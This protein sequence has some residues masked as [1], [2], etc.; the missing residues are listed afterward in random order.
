MQNSNTILLTLAI[1]LSACAYQQVSY[2]QDVAPILDKNCNEC[3]MSPNGYGYKMIGL[4]LDSYDSIIQGTV[5]GSIIV[6]G[7]SSR[8]LLNK[9]AE[10][11][12]GKKRYN[13]HDAKEDISKEEIEVLKLWVDQGALNN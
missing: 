13:M 6:P 9:L 11:R 10:G 1:I 5:Y 3:H 8:S 2:K 12:V 7:D 4:K